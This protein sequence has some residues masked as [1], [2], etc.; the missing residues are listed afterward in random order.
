MSNIYETIKKLDTLLAGWVTGSAME[1]MATSLS[2][3]NLFSTKIILQLFMSSDI[4][5]F[6]LK[7]LEYQCFYTTSAAN[8]HE[9]NNQWR[10]DTPI[11]ETHFSNKL[12]FQKTPLQNKVLCGKFEVAGCFMIKLLTLNNYDE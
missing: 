12:N 7:K 8:Q 6:L 10:H 9:W 3:N 11:V 2:D 5:L 1:H 4:T